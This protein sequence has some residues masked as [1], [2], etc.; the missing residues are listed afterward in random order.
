MSANPADNGRIH[1]LQTFD[2]A[3]RA[4]GHPDGAVPPEGQPDAEF[5]IAA[6]RHRCLRA[7][8]P[9]VGV[10]VLVRRYRERAGYS[11]SALAG[12]LGFHPSAINRWESGDR[13]RIAPES[14]AALIA[15]LELSDEEA[16]ALL[17]AVGYAPTWLDDATVRQT[18][19]LLRALPGPQRRRFRARIAA[20]YDEIAEGEDV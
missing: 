3:L 9:A 13:P 5:R 16:E 18:A 14:A 6:I 20:L 10:G 12:E 1:P 17:E 4:I 7:T 8:L 11:Q 19:A 15:G 2:S